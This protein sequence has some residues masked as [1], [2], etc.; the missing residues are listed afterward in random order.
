M[1]GPVLCIYRGSDQVMAVN[2]CTTS[3]FTHVA[4]SGTASFFSGGYGASHGLA[5]SANASV[6]CPALCRYLIS[7]ELEDGAIFWTLKSVKLSF[8]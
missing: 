3:L 6:M 7:I 2:W 5:T 1:F 8:C 4:P